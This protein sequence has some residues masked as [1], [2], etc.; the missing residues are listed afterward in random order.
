MKR[1]KQFTIKINFSNRWLY[2]FIALGILIVAG[3]GV[4]AYGSGSP[5]TFGHSGDEINVDST[6]CSRVTG[7]S[8]GYDIDT[9]TDTRGVSSCTAYL[10]TCQFYFT[11]VTETVAYP[12]PIGTIYLK[13]CP[14]G[15]IMAGVS[16]PS[17]YTQVI[18]CC[19]LRTYC[20]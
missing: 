1:G 12:A 7:H 11:G 15:T 9:D 5:T 4:Y 8:C 13:S 10:G 6:F 17:A 2:T 18:K 3:I 20:S 19:D 14:A 16:V